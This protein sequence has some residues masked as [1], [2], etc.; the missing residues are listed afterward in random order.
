MTGHERH[1]DDFDALAIGKMLRDAAA[2]GATPNWQA[3]GLERVLRSA[4]LIERA[5]ASHF[6]IRAIAL[7]AATFAL[8]AG[9]GWWVL[10][11]NGKAISFEVQGA[12]LNSTNYVVATPSS[13][14]R[15]KFSDGSSVELAHDAQ[16]RV[17]Q[18]TPHG[19]VLVLER[20]AAVT[21]VVHRTQSNWKVLAGPFEI[22]VVGTRFQ[23]DWDPA[24][25]TLRVNLYEGTLRIG[26]QNGIEL[27]VIKQG[28]RFTADGRRASWGILPIPAAT[29]Q[30][31]AEEQPEVAKAQSSDLSV[32]TNGGTEAE[33]TPAHATSN[34]PGRNAPRDWS[35]SVAK[36]DFGR[37]V[38]E[39]EARGISACLNQCSIADLR[40]LADAARYTRRF[41][42]SEQALMALRRRAPHDAANAAYLLGALN[43]TQGR[44]MAALRW[45]FQSATEAP[46]GRYISEAQ[47]GRL[48][49]LVATKQTQAAREVAT[50]YLRE[51]PHGVGEATA[52]KVL[53]TTP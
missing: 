15:M 12:E 23:T 9:S 24:T 51:F 35:A 30:P 31:G 21:H 1:S 33:P 16:L 11:Q 53:S 40:Q 37:V 8:A 48:R 25:E 28:Q 47:A 27:T 29:S 52:R 2:S 13:S 10:R 44:S 45:Y 20:G 6:N 17:Q 36:G 43:E 42:L 50:E 4:S 34:A 19:A 46:Q 49:M 22:A 32:N 26:G 7:A 38:T 39:A 3:I 14:A 5:K 18:V 41:Q